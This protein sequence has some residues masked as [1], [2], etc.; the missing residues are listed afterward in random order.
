MSYQRKL[1][2]DMSNIGEPGPLPKVLQGSL[3][4][5]DLADLSWLP[6]EI[7]GYE[8]QGFFWVDDVVAPMRRILDKAVVHSRVSA[9][10]KLGAVWAILQSDPD[11]LGRWLMPGRPDVY[12][13]DEG[14]LAVLAAA[15]CSEGETAE[16]TAP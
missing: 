10:G 9:L 4:D 5:A 6:P 7:T 13:D 15:G 2:A 3:S 14:L 1:L 16:I 8:G 12:A 11:L